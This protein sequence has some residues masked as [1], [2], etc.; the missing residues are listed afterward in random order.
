MGETIVGPEEQGQY[1]KRGYPLET[2]LQMA[3]RHVAQQE[4]LIAKQTK[5]IASLQQSGLP[6]DTAED[7]LETMERLLII[8]RQDAERLEQLARSSMA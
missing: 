6:I 4:V 8:F 3:R 5:L 7:V 2:P 1:T